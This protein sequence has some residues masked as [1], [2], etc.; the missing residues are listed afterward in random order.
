MF[1]WNFGLLNNSIF[2]QLI[3]DLLK[4]TSIKIIKQCHN[5][6]Q[7]SIYFKSKNSINNRKS[8]H[9]SS[10]DP[11]LKSIRATKQSLVQK[12]FKWKWIQTFK[13]NIENFPNNVIFSFATCVWT[14]HIHLRQRFIQIWATFFWIWNAIHILFFYSSIQY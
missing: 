6:P 3:D 1:Q 4:I 9:I 5:S 2:I 8:P 11:D 7:T 14:R 10:I 13:K 12:F